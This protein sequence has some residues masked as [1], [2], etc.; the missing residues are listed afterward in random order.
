M[1]LAQLIDTEELEGLSP[2]ELRN[3]LSQLDEEVVANTTDMTT[4]AE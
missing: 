2:D 3:M 4:V 1:I